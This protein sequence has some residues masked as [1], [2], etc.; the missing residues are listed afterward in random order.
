MDLMSACIYGD[1]FVETQAPSRTAIYVE[2]AERER[3]RGESGSSGKG[4]REALGSADAAA[5]AFVRMRV[6]RYLRARAASELPLV[7]V[8][9]AAHAATAKGSSENIDDPG[10]RTMVR[11]LERVHGWPEPPW[12]PGEEDAV[13]QAAAE[14]GKASV[15]A[16][17]AALPP[18]RQRGHT[19]GPPGAGIGREW[20]A[21]HFPGP[22]GG[23]P[24]NEYVY[25]LSARVANTTQ[26]TASEIEEAKARLRADFVV[27][28]TEQMPSFL[29]LV[30]V[31]DR[32]RSVEG[33]QKSLGQLPQRGAFTP[34]PHPACK[35]RYRYY[36]TSTYTPRLPF[37][38]PLFFIFQVE[39]GWPLK[40]L[41]C[42]ARNVNAATGGTKAR[43]PDAIFAHAER[44]LAADLEV[45]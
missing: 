3:I 24:P 5:R 6:E 35:T 17:V 33:R 9:L 8:L 14:A 22:P 7:D 21:R 41:C 16:A 27:G 43:L 26:P 30:A 15:A 19:L 20:K 45:S 11:E 1:R 42:V 13:R 12:L 18:Q 25:V 44:K 36:K 28:L 37:S 34:T 2:H 40:Y 29:V 4:G 39:L 32:R 23:A 31:R 10:G 38:P